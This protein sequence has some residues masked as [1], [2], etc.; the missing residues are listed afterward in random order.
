MRTW[1]SLFAT[2]PT[3]KWRGRLIGIPV[4]RSAAVRELLEEFRAV[5][6]FPPEDVVG[7]LFVVL[8]RQLDQRPVGPRGSVRVDWDFEPAQRLD[9]ALHRD[10]ERIQVLHPAQERRQVLRGRLREV[11][12]LG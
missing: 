12:G 2:T 9:R 4:Y 10:L 5:E 3:M 6:V 1:S 8:A 11:R 7:L